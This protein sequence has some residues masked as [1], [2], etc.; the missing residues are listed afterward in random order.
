MSKNRISVP[1]NDLVRIHKPLI[2]EFNDCLTKIIQSSGFVNG[3]IV[4]E[5]ENNLAQAEGLNYA[6]STSTGTSAIELTLK[7]LGIGPGDEVLTTSFTFVATVHSILQ[8]G[9]MPVL[10][11]VNENDCLI[12][13]EL[14]IKGI[15]KKTK[16]II[17][18]SLH[19]RLD[20]V[21]LYETIAKRHGLYLILDASQ[22]HLARWDNNNQGK[23]FDA[24]TLSFYPG[25][26]L[27][28]L[29]E[30]G[31]VL[32]NNFEIIEKIKIMKDW[33]SKQKYVHDYWGGNYRMH[34]IQ[35]G[36]LN[37]KLPYLLG[38]TIERKNLA[39]K[40]IDNL[41]PHILNL[42]ISKQGDNVYH[43]FDVLIVDREKMITYLTEQ[44]ISTGI[45]YP[46]VV[47]DNKAYSNK[48]KQLSA[49]DNAL[50]LAKT[51]LSLPLFPGL[52]DEEQESV[53]YAV[54]SYYD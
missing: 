54:N 22:S 40:Y 23:Y 29:G 17:V 48:V 42:P 8:V 30:G 52:T 49:C 24:I 21:D 44:N 43:I 35:A 31:A 20:H 25:K 15:S 32:S 46:R 37:I 14:T 36:F 4:S 3:Q 18:V 50:K 33:G 45:H 53:I 47:Q 39:R 12:D 2:P 51:T 9:A 34:S 26:N 10:V 11:D 38:W 41:T 27:G 16:A 28:S 6:A 19:G 7:A 1:F 13:P 5:F